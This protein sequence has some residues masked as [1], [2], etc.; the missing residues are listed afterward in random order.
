VAVVALAGASDDG[1]AVLLCH[2]A[3]LMSGKP[4]TVAW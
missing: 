1:H 2:Y 4:A 3:P